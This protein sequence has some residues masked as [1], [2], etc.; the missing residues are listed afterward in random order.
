MD[1]EFVERLLLASCTAL[2]EFCINNKIDSN[3]VMV[4]E[5]C[6]E[7]QMRPYTQ[8]PSPVPGQEA[9]NFMT[10]IW[11]FL[12]QQEKRWL[13]FTSTSSKNLSLRK[14]SWSKW[15]YSP[16]T[17]TCLSYLAPGD[18]S[19]LYSLAGPRQTWSIFTRAIFQIPVFTVHLCIS[20]S[21]IHQTNQFAVKFVKE[22]FPSQSWDGFLHQL[23]KQ[24]GETQPDKMISN[25]FDTTQLAEHLKRV[26]EP[27]CYRIILL[28]GVIRENI[29]DT[30]L[31]QT[32]HAPCSTSPRHSAHKLKGHCI[33]INIY[34]IY[35][36]SAPPRPW[37]ILLPWVVDS[38]RD[39]GVSTV[40]DY[41]RLEQSAMHFLF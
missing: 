2:G 29:L 9:T 5:D 33:N 40:P 25:S 39:V 22:T 31:Q 23:P 38:N 17:V 21:H 41:Q 1:K 16:T 20:L 15:T 14:S 34:S 35:C 13:R 12:G 3:N 37:D 7:N 28:V 6:F 36:M 30:E 26:F 27:E 8:T 10:I 24:V 32:I 19:P 11:E 4:S 18:L